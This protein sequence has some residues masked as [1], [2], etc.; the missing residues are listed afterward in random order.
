MNSWNTWLRKNWTKAEPAM[1]ASLRKAF[2]RPQY[3]DEYDDIIQQFVT[4]LLGKEEGCY[5]ERSFDSNLYLI[6]NWC[7]LRGQAMRAR[8]IHHA[9]VSLEGIEVMA[10]GSL[11]DAFVERDREKEVS[12]LV[13]LVKGHVSMR[14]F[15]IWQ[16]HLK[17]TPHG[18]IAKSHKVNVCVV[19]TVA[20]N[21][22]RFLMEEMGN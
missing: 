22:K 9:E 21:V 3:T 18:D 4:Y 5:E 11:E 1:K 2:G 12:R 10:E 19:N 8:K 6:C 13:N 16:R 15:D 14:D 7:V 17:G 20:R